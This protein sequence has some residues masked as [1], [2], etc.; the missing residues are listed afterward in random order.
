MTKAFVA[1]LLP[2]GCDG[3]LLIGSGIADG[4]GVEITIAE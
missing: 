2:L 1:K 3:V 4:V